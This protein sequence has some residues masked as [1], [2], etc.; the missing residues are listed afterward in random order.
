MNFDSCLLQILLHQQQVHSGK[1]QGFTDHIKDKENGK[2]TR[3][4]KKDDIVIKGP[5]TYKMSYMSL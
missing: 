3:D 4:N 1:V 5:K 2:W